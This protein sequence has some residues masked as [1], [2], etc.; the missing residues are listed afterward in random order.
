MS[1]SICSIITEHTFG[2]TL[3]KDIS[4]KL[5]SLREIVRDFIELAIVLQLTIE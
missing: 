1:P 2:F 5:M 3:K 4:A